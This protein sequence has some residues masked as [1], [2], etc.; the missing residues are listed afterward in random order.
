[1][2]QVNKGMEAGIRTWLKSPT[3]ES[4]AKQ[5]DQW[6]PSPQD[7]SLDSFSGNKGLLPATRE[8]VHVFWEA[9]EGGVGQDTKA[10][11][12]QVSG[13]HG[14]FGL[15]PTEALPSVRNLRIEQVGR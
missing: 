5:P 4:K 12:V 13:V 2:G 9:G 1:M 7:R 15:V 6:L 10:I 3:T 14:D 11:S 8:R